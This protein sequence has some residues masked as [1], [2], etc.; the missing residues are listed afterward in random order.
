VAA[1]PVRPLANTDY[2]ARFTGA[3]GYAP[4]GSSSR[5]V[6]VRPQLTATLSKTSMPLG[7]TTR[8]SGGVSPRHAGQYVYLQNYYSGA[9]PTLRSARLSSTST[10]AFYM[11]PAYRGTYYF[12]VYKR[13]DADHA[14]AVTGYRTLRVY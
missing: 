11:R 8:L 14:M 6:Y 10:Y 4:S 9:W 5:A 13:A 1:F 2:Y 12:R 3:T 7:G